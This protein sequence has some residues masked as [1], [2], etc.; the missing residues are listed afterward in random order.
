MISGLVVAYEIPCAKGRGHRLMVPDGGGVSGEDAARL[1]G[2]IRGPVHVSADRL[3]I[4]RPTKQN[5]RG[6]IRDS[7]AKAVVVGIDVFR[8]PPSTV[9][10][11]LAALEASLDEAFAEA[12]DSESID[13]ATIL[14]SSVATRMV[15]SIAAIGFHQFSDPLPTPVVTRGMPTPNPQGGGGRSEAHQSL[16]V[17]S[18]AILVSGIAIGWIASSGIGK[19]RTVAITPHTGVPPSEETLSSAQDT[20]AS[21]HSHTE[22]AVSRPAELDPHR[23]V[24]GS[25][26]PDGNSQPAPT[27]AST[28][29]QPPPRRGQGDAT[30]AANPT[31]SP[32]RTLQQNAEKTVAPSIVFHVQCKGTVKGD[33]VQLCRRKR[34]SIPNIDLCP[35]NVTMI[36]REESA[37][38]NSVSFEVKATDN[39]STP[40]SIAFWCAKT[41]RWY[42][43][44]FPIPSSDPTFH[45]LK[46]TDS[47]NSYRCQFSV[48][49]DPDTPD[50]PVAVVVTVED[51]SD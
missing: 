44:L 24:H 30:D 27:T 23:P 20:I 33:R 16:L 14:P 10:S 40:E 17:G 42:S 39:A 4:S 31:Q 19:G 51:S 48:K 22:P 45:G 36:G 47:G 5:A 38:S 50:R 11:A 8:A 25:A 29:S 12:S 13:H 6:T 46:S 3:G 26:A 37:Q 35:E 15:D 34:D 41:G 1:I 2:S 21:G 32:P 49:N 18:M 43:K 9:M 7:S 28:P